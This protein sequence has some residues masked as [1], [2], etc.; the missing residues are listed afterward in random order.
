MAA[1][2]A[3]GKAQILSEGGS[4]A[5]RLSSSRANKY[6]YVVCVQNTTP[7]WGSPEAKHHEAFLVGRI[8]SV[9]KSKEG[10]GVRWILNFDAY[11][12]ISVAD[13]WDGNRNPVAYSH[14]E[15]M[16]I[17]IDDLDFKK[18]PDPVP[19]SNN[20]GIRPLTL[21][22]AKEGLALNFC[23]DKDDIEITIKG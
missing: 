6:E 14:L 10:Q 17:D 21:S 15:D 1:F 4:Q 7:T 19:E 8:S 9:T 13:Q 22:E 12:D 20:S 23:V 11:A 18:M 16:G 5:W 3:R 2:T